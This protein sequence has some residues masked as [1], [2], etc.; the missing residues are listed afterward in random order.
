MRFLFK[1]LR[2]FFSLL[3]SLSLMKPH[4]IDHPKVRRRRKKSENKS[5][6]VGSLKTILHF[7]LFIRNCCPHLCIFEHETFELKLFSFICKTFL[8]A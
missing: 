8:L 6:T 3:D 1:S 7:L 5:K 4:L 2:L